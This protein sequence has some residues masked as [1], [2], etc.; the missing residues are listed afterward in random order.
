[1]EKKKILKNMEFISKS[2]QS[3]LP[4]DGIH[5]RKCHLSDIESIRYLQPIGWDEITF[6]FRF[7]CAHSFCYPVVAVAQEKIVGVATGILN[8]KTG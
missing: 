7:Y 4:E 3:N 2:D 6:Y 5:I 1:M 8:K